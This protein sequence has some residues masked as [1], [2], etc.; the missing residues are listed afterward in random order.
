[1]FHGRPIAKK[2]LRVNLE[3]VE[4]NV[5][6]IVPVEDA[7][8]TKLEDAFGSL[9]LWLRDLSYLKNKLI[10][11]NG[12]LFEVEMKEDGLDNTEQIKNRTPVD[13]VAT[14]PSM[15][16]ISRYSSFCTYHGHSFSI[17]LSSSHV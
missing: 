2:Y 10:G 1:M 7:D 14:N 17:S 11:E 8:Q 12:K 3:S 13:T 4:V 6:L 5:F 9:V 16:P 15:F